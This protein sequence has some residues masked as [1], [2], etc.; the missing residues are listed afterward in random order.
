[1]KRMGNER[2]E[3][4]EDPSET[5]STYI[6]L[7]AT[8]GVS[9]HMG[10]IDATEELIELCHID[11]AIYVFDVGCGIG[12]TISHLAQ[13]YSC[14]VVGLDISEKMINTAKETAKN[15]GTEKSIDLILADAQHLP[16]RS[17]L[18]G[19]VICESV[20]SFIKDKQRALEEYIRVTKPEG[21]IGMNE[22][23]WIEIPPPEIVEHASSNLGT[24]IISSKEWEELIEESGLRE[25]VTRTY[26]IAPLKELI[27]RI[28][29]IG[30]TRI[31]KA[32]FRLF[33]LYIR[34][35]AIRN[36]LK[37]EL[38]VPGATIKYMGYGIYVG[39]K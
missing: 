2:E 16:L 4:Q 7:Q 37:E 36:E 15:E 28:R 29:L 30:L 33:F 17:D 10:G 18:F 3:A 19:S 26:E 8:L 6:E 1:V 39:K 5:E 35:P 24:E 9:K 11:E 14:E 23:I 21:Y 31:L 20:N 34:D 25:T 32:W 13:K 38:S 12:I 22:A 27:D